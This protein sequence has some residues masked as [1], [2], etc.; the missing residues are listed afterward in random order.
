MSTTI[1]EVLRWAQSQALALRNR[2]YDDPIPDIESA[3]RWYEHLIG[4]W[5]QEE[6]SWHEYEK[7]SRE[8]L[9][10]S[11]QFLKGLPNEEAWDL[12]RQI[13]D[14]IGGEHGQET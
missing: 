8:L 5:Q 13:T 3:R 11:C 4:S 12:T 6:E 14:L 2:G 1:E 7:R 9:E 10:K